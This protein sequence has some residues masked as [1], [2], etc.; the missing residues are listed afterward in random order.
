M[1]P[2]PTV[3]RIAPSRSRPPA[4][5]SSRLSANLKETIASTTAASGILMKNAHRHERCW[6]SQPP[7]TGPSPADI[8]ENP[9][10][11]PIARPRSAELNDELIKARLPGTISAPPSPCADR[12]RISCSVSAAKPHHIELRANIA[13]P[14]PNT[15]RRPNLSPNAPPTSIKAERKSAYDSTIH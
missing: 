11:T 8:A 12:A 5:S 1:L 7:S 2:R 9:D 4:M 14:Y 3:A 13:T 10:H 15:L 6:T